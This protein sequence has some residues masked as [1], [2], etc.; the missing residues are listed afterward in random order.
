MHRSWKQHAAKGSTALL[1]LHA[2]PR[3]LCGNSPGRIDTSCL[4][5]MTVSKMCRKKYIN[6]YIFVFTANWAPPLSFYLGHHTPLSNVSCC[7]ILSLAAPCVH[8]FVFASQVLLFRAGTTPPPPPQKKHIYALT[9]FSAARSCTFMALPN[10]RIKPKSTS[11]LS[12]PPPCE[13]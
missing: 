2:C 8:F 3:R 10:K 11:R 13:S 12:D 6:I 7:A 4:S 5:K 1:L 9:A